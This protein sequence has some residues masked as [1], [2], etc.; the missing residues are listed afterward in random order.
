MEKL[1]KKYC[2]FQWIEECQ[3]RFDTLK[4]KM[5]T[6]PILV[7]PDWSKEFHV[8]VDASSIALG[9]VLAQPGAIDI[10]HMLS[11]SSRKI[12]T[13]KINYTTTERE[14]LAMVY[15]LEKFHHYLL[16]GHFKMFIDHSALKYLVNK[17]MFGER[18]CKWLLLFQEY[19]FEIVVKLR[20]MDKGPNHL[21]RLEH[22]EEPTSLEDT[23]PYAQFLAIRN[24][25]DHFAK[26]VQ[27]LSTAMALH[28]CTIIQKKQ[29]VVRAADFSLIARQLYKM[30]PDEI[31]R[32]CVME[33]ERP[34]ILA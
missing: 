31:L 26:I 28:K 12:S 11:F 15:V 19:D 8:H 7:F 20:R 4:Q 21:S 17:P 9:E 3:Q 18:I 16:G 30:G 25:D 6:A 5:V 2:Q 10:D 22:G 34:L 33:V 1:L 27:F 29:L 14:G 32:R 24:I 13:A 23:L